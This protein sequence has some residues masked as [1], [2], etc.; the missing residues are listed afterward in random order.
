M[1][2]FGNE[3]LFDALRKGFASP[4]DFIGND[5]F[6]VGRPLPALSRRFFRAE[7]VRLSPTHPFLTPL[8]ALLRIPT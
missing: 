2:F 5:D 8:L 4:D 1:S 7:L 6:P 3:A